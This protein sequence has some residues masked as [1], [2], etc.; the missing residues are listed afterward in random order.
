VSQTI[1]LH[2]FSI[3]VLIIISLSL[4]GKSN[5]LTSSNR[6]FF[7]LIWLNVSILLVSI[8]RALTNG[9]SDPF[10]H[11]LYVCSL[12]IYFVLISVIIL[13]WF[14]YVNYFMNEH[15]KHFKAILS[16]MIPYVII[17]AILAH[18]SP[19]YGY[20]FSITESYSATPGPLYP[21]IFV[22]SVVLLFLS[23]LYVF[24]HRHELARSDYRSLVMFT[25]PPMVAAFIQPFD[26]S[27]TILW[28]AMTLS[29]LIIYVNIQSKITNTDP[30]TGVYNRREFDRLSKQIEQLKVKEKVAAIMID[31]DDFKQINDEF[32]HQMGDLTLREIADILKRSVR[33][34]DFISRIGG[35]EFCIIIQIEKDDTLFDIVRRIHENIHYFNRRRLHLIPIKLSMGYGIYEESYYSGFE[36]FLNKLDRKMYDDKQSSKQLV[37]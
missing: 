20:V 4:R 24:L 36:D 26:P 16:F 34:D 32:S 23:I 10:L 37:N 17:N 1:Q 35:D 31:I 27:G 5:I 2:V 18:L 25:L 6:Y 28:P 22:V 15:R 9:E 14:L 7:A 12:V 8:V 21:L 3:V 19:R 30:L 13:F 11:G 33:K 29:I